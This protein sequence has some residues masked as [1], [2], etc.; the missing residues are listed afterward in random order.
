MIECDSCEDWYHTKCVEL[1]ESLPAES[2]QIWLCSSC[3]WLHVDLA[4]TLDLLHY[5]VFVPLITLSWS[6]EFGFSPC[7]YPSLSCEF[8]FARR[9]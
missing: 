6:S 9:V 3:T 1:G 4:R 7:C 2:S 5:F 8:G